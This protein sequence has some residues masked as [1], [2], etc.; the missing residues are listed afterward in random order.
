MPKIDF[1]EV[2]NAVIRWCWIPVVCF[3]IGAIG[4]F[5]YVSTL[6]VLYTSYGSLYIK[7]KAP[8]V[9]SGNPL[10]QE[11]SNDLEKMKT[12]EQG[13]LS[14]T[15]LLRVAEKHNLAS[16]PLF[17]AG[18]LEP[19]AILDTLSSRVSIELR[20]GTRLMDIQ[21]KDTDPQR[22]SLIVESI[23]EEY[24]DW[25]DG[26]RSDLVTKTTAQLAAQEQRMREKMV[27][28]EKR[29]QEFRAE[30]SVLGLSGD[31]ER[32]QTSKLELLNQELSTAEN[33]RLRLDTQF[34]ALAARP[35]GVS[36]PNLAARG[37]RGQL[38]LALEGDIAAKKAEFAKIKER[39]KYKHPT[40]IEADNEL[41]RLEQSLAQVLAEAEAGLE[42]DLKVSL[43]REKE[44]KG[45]VEEAK[46][47]AINDEGIREEFSQLTRA[48]EIDRNLHSRV[49][50]QLQETQIGAALSASFLSWDAHPLV[51]VE[52]SAPNK[53]G[54]VLVGCFL[55]GLL[56]TG[57]A[58]LFAISDPRVREPSALERKLRVPMLARLPVYGRDVINDLSVSGDGMA[59]LN[60]PAHLARYTPTPREGEEQ[61]QSLL[62]ASPF[63]GDGK[64]LCVMKCARTMVKQG[65]RTLVIDADFSSPGLSREYSRQRAGRHGLAAYLMGEA[66]PAEVLFETGL[67]GLWFLPTGGVEGDSGDLLSGPGLRQLLSAITPM[68][69]RVI[70]DMSS[71][72]ECDDVQAVARHIGAT[73]LVAQKGKG[74]YRHLKETGEIL[75]SAGANVTG[76][77]WNDGG[78]RRRRGDRGPVIE[79]VSYPSEV[80]EVSPKGENEPMPAP[81]PA[82]QSETHRAV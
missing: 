15:V 63:D 2:L 41:K 74:K 71:A 43:S 51:P 8:E 38:V 59:M 50:M 26:G 45:L 72:L 47:D 81:A 12:V 73:Y 46:T 28:S 21:V 25:Q 61:M 68:V 3:I 57:L 11:G 40:F 36:A 23:V 10:A 20:K 18:G 1:R 14:A 29:L 77:I 78:R 42:N 34:R 27:E 48:A 4:M 79:P 75:V 70:F 54:L 30:N 65:Y 19:Q 53:L 69:D 64:T 5:Y 52:P 31:Q 9:F 32:L 66:E 67:P 55:G 44:L 76:F 49:A 33:E 37:E 24:E 62:F 22:A 17:Q 60:R 35:D 6:P 56:G 13:L 58:L 39:Y 80:R 7:T 82:P 16:D